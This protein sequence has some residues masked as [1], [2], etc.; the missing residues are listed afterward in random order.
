M[1]HVSPRA[2]S[3]KLYYE[4]N[5]ELLLAKRKAWYAANKQRDRDNHRKWLDKNPEKR[6]EYNKRA[7]KKKPEQLYINSLRRLYNL[8]KEQ[9]DEMLA[10]QGGVCA[11]C[12]RKNATK[13]LGVDHDHGTGKVRELLC[14]MCNR[15][16][17]Y[18]KDDIA[19]LKAATAY[20][21]KH[22]CRT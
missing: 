7:I 20:L 6:S 15:G 14:D 8:T 18:L 11:I 17:G 12:S 13:R 9:Y 4:K 1:R 2:E 22:K 16:I 5:K 19:L 3:T 10:A 21:E